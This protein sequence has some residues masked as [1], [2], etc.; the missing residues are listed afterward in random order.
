MNKKLTKIVGIALGLIMAVG[1][2]ASIV[3]GNKQA[4]QVCA[5]EQPYAVCDFTLKTAN[6]NSYSSTISYG[7]YSVYGGANNNGGWEYYKF[8]A[9]KAKAADE[10]KVTDN[11]VKSPKLEEKITKV[12]L[13][14]LASSV[15][16]TVTWGVEI[17]SDSSFNTLVDTVSLTS[18][19][20]KTA[21]TYT[22][23]PSSGDVKVTPL[24][25]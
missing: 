7:N 25:V 18:I 8:G 15:N 21:G 5:E 17:F 1:V 2:G 9:K 6:S 4:H 12:G 19:A 22:L 20:H 10:T 13:Q 14:I 23:T 3:T 11:W 24:N 16:G